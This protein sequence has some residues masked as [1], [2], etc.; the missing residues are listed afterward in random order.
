VTLI[1]RIWSIFKDYRLMF[2]K[3]VMN[4]EIVVASVRSLKYDWKWTE[5]KVMLFIL[6]LLEYSKASF[7]IPQGSLLLFLPHCAL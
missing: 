1:G 6:F 7:F 3:T 2:A 5:W 4:G